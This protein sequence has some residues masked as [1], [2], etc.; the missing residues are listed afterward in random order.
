[1]NFE[2]DTKY[3]FTNKL[4]QVTLTHIKAELNKT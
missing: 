2:N 3:N 1:M 4:N